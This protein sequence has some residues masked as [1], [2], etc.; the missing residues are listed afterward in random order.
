[1]P[2]TTSNIKKLYDDK[3]LTIECANLLDS[4]VCEA[5]SQNEFVVLADSGEVFDP[6]GNVKDW[7][8]LINTML[9]NGFDF[10]LDHDGIIVNTSEGMLTFN[11]KNIGRRLTRAF[12]ELYSKKQTVKDNYYA[13]N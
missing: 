10:A 5:R 1:M 9:V 6:I 11:D 13:N 7:G 3:S 12:V 4:F 2:N 8:I